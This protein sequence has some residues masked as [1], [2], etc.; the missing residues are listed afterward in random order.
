MLLLIQLAYRSDRQDVN[1]KKTNIQKHL[2]TPPRYA[3]LIWKI[4]GPKEYDSHTGLI[5]NPAH[6]GEWMIKIL[7]N[8]LISTEK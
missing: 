7:L 4:Q 8:I 3:I 2:T 6:D 1:Q 5:Y